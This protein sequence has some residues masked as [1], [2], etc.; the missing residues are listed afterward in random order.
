MNGTFDNICL[1]VRLSNEPANDFY[2][3][4][5]FEILG[6]KKNYFWFQY[7]IWKNL[8]LVSIFHITIQK[9]EPSAYVKSYSTAFSFSND[10]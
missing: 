2:R 9:N 10:S 7:Q 6:T 8:D 4:F 5:G 3:K 1:H